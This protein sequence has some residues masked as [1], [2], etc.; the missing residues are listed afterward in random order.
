[1]KKDVQMVNYQIKKEI[2]MK[3]GKLN[4][5]VMGKKKLNYLIQIQK[6]YILV[7]LLCKKMKQHGL[8]Y[9]Q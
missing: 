8:K 4:Y 9:N 5:L 6:D 7:Q 1:M 3:K 2:D